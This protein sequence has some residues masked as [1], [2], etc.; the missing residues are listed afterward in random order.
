MQS[1]RKP[2]L[3]PALSREKREHNLAVLGKVTVQWFSNDC[4]KYLPLPGGEGWGEGEL[5][6]C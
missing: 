3:T 2:A 4:R 5:Y 1:K 6:S